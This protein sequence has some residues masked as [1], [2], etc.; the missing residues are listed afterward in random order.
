MV[1]VD[2]C[3]RS[4]RGVLHLFSRAPRPWQD[5][6]L[7]FPRET[8]EGLEKR[9]QVLEELEGIV[10]EWIVEEGE[11]KGVQEG[12]AKIVTLGSYRCHGFTWP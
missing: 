6:E 5:L 3:S 4:F 9:E 2:G 11:A 7:D 1:Y 8:R 10:S 12:S